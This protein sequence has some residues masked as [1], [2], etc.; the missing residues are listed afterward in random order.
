MVFRRKIIS[1]LF[2]S[3]SLISFF[4][5]KAQTARPNVLLFVADDM[6]W[7]YISHIDTNFILNT[8]AINS[9]A[10][11][12]AD[13]KFYTTNSVCLPSRASIMSGLYGHNN[14]S[15]NNGQLMTHSEVRLPQLMYDNGYYV[16]LIGKWMIEHKQPK[17][18]FDYWLW[19]P[20]QSTYYNDTAFYFDSAVAV[21][22]H[23]TDFITDSALALL[24]RID[25][26]FFLIVDHNAPHSPFI[27]QNQYANMYDSTTFPLPANFIEYT[28]NYPSYLYQFDSPMLPGG[29]ENMLK[30][31]IPMIK[32]IDEGLQK[33]LDELDSI[34]Q[35]DNTMI[36]FISDNSYLIGDHRLQG[37]SY[38][39]EDCMRAPLF[40]RYPAWFTPGT[41]ID[42]SYSLNIDLMPTILEAAGI[43]DT[44]IIDGV[45]VHKVMTEN[46][47][48]KEFLYEQF[49]QDTVYPS[50]RTIEDDYFVYSRYFCTDTTEE[51]FDRKNDPLQLNNLVHHFAYLDTLI[52][53][54]NRLDSLRMVYHDTAS[55]DICDC[56]LL[57]PVYVNDTVTTGINGNEFS[58]SILPNPASNQLTVSSNQSAVFS[59]S[60]YDLLGREMFHSTNNLHSEIINLK[61]FPSGIYFCVLKTSDGK[62]SEQKLVIEK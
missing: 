31:Y 23:M 1:F 38:P 50:E 28:Q 30:N 2:V 53:Y 33:V 7:N 25:T 13:I 8:P 35:K 10:E 60:I 5:S 62:M 48:R 52:I 29:Y 4:E 16:A 18:D 59:I 27:P 26:P 19:T 39:Y 17:P 42:S 54:R 36:I 40:I 37:K 55:I 24:S 61:S 9:I 43:T 32:G 44:A 14:G 45:S 47:R 20:N 51:L 22:E 49:P 11:Q 6:R 21:T 57:N 15:M 46:F 58:F 3:L 12:G 34:E 56:S 41:V